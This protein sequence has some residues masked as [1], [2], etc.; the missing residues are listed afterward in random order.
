MKIMEYIYDNHRSV[1]E[2]SRSIG[3]DPSTI[4]QILNKKRKPTARMLYK[5]KKATNGQITEKDFEDLLKE[6][7][8][9]DV[10]ESQK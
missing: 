9:E 5:I 1:S 6:D 10:E 8:C 4:S 3:Y 2:F 7:N